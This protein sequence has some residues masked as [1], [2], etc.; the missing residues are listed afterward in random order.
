MYKIIENQ[1]G[2]SSQKS[3]CLKISKD[4]VKAKIKLFYDKRIVNMCS[5]L[6]P[7]LI[8]HGKMRAASK[9]K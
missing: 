3:Y 5:N 9:L 2:A 4:S 1:N 8:L 6:S 7:I